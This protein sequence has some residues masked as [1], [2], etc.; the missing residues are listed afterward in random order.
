[1]SHY[2]IDTQKELEAV[3]RLAARSAIGIDTE[4]MRVRTYYPKLA[5]VQVSVGNVIYCIDPLVEGLRL[6]NL[7]A[8]LAE[9][10]TCKVMHSARQDIEVLFHTAN[11]MPAPLFDTQIAAGLLGYAGQVGYA[12]LVKTEFGETLSKGAQ[13]TDWTKRPLA[14]A[15]LTYAENDVRYLLPLRDRLAA[16]LKSHDRL[17]WATEDFRRV[18][19]PAL[20]E[21]DPFQVYRRVGKGAYLEPRSQHSLKRLCT[22]REHT[23]RRRNLPRHWVL[24]DENLVSIAATGPQS[25]QDLEYIKGLRHDVVRRDGEVIV[26]CINGA[27]DDG[28]PLWSKYQVL[29]ADQKMLKAKLVGALKHRA[30]TL[31]LSESVLITR[32]DIEK[33]VRGASSRKTIRGWRWDV[34][35][36]D[37]ENMLGYIDN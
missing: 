28:E 15:Q 8:I 32:S 4:F 12:D 27:S 17:E 19:D 36:R 3:C 26:N 5:L 35:G 16:R 13:R 20:Y 33:L 6:D 7:W 9:S 29:T 37:F 2:L 31:G 10:G 24:D 1:M 21:I 22:W 11:V 23:A 18:L 25:V 30:T 14:E 34:I